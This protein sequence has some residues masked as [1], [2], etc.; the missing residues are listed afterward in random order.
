M[1]SIEEMFH[2]K[3][4]AITLLTYVPTYGGNSISVTALDRILAATSEIP[5][6]TVLDWHVLDLEIRKKDGQQ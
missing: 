1:D 3:V 2:G 6:C 4:E 5:E